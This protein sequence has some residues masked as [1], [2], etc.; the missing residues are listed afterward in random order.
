MQTQQVTDIIGRTRLN[1]FTIA[2]TSNTDTQVLAENWDRQALILAASTSI[3]LL[4]KLGQVVSSSLFDGILI[5]TNGAAVKLLRSEIGD[6]ISAALHVMPVG[7]N[8]NFS[9]LEVILTGP[10]GAM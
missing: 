9:G 10:A 2:L 8:A 6:Q 1:W 4:F 5:P 7:G 3:N